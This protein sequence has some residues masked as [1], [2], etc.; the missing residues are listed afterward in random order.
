MGDLKD[1]RWIYAKGFLFLAIGL[2]SALLLILE[3]PTLKIT[4]LLLL[5]VWSFCRC[6]YFAFYVIQHYVDGQYRFAGLSSFVG[7]LWKKLRKNTQ[8]NQ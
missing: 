7:Y 6:Y 1:A 2:L 5:C 8:K 3:H 4:A